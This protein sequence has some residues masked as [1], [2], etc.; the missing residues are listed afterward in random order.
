M[1]GRVSL[2]SPITV[3]I[4]GLTPNTTLKQVSTFVGQFC[5]G[6]EVSFPTRKNALKCR[7]FA[8]VRVQTMEDAE[9][10]L[11]QVS[12]IDGSKVRCQLALDPQ[13]K[14]DYEKN[15]QQ[16]K[17][18][19]GDLP[20]ELDVDRLSARLAT[21]GTLNSC[22]KLPK[23]SKGLCSAL[24]E[25]SD[26]EAAIKVVRAGL[27]VDG[28]RLQVNFYVRNHKQT[29][30]VS[31]S[32]ESPTNLHNNN[33][34]TFYGATVHDP[35]MISHKRNYEADF[36]NEEPQSGD[37]SRSVRNEIEGS[38]LNYRFRVATGGH[39]LLGCC[40]LKTAAGSVI[41]KQS[42][43]SLQLTG[44]P[45]SGGPRGVNRIPHDKPTWTYG[46]PTTPFQS[47]V[48]QAVQKT[49]C[50]DLQGISANITTA[51]PSPG[52]KSKRNFNEAAFNFQLKEVPF[53]RERRNDEPVELVESTRGAI[54]P[55]YS[56]YNKPRFPMK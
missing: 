21:F 7:G 36:N 54:V 46:G 4:G 38:S 29:K 43:H 15:L 49:Q 53:T 51:S 55:E 23:S 42:R 5:S 16:R 24:A 17:I 13:A 41:L 39:R 40:K 22:Y 8:F 45:T 37:M 28:V 48:S 25:F 9:R 11:A 1:A 32:P 31:T 56:F 3:F 52:K 35:S 26:P 2:D 34:S 47:R 50:D 10:L 18:Y 14:Q 19:I 20:D 6:A 33:S 30:A 44:E 12:F 27:K